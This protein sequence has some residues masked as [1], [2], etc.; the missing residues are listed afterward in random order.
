MKQRKRRAGADPKTL[1][2][3][4]LSNGKSTKTMSV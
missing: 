1:N 4:N 2:A 3:E